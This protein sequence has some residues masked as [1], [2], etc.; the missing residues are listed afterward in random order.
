MKTGIRNQGSGIRDQG[1]GNSAAEETLRLLARLHA[2]EGLEERVQENLRVATIPAAHQARILNWPTWLRPS[3][4]WM[5]SSGMRA[6]AAAA[7]VAVV[8][9]GGWI[10]SSRLPAAQPGVAV[11][12]SPRGAAPGG[13]SSA[14]AMRTPQ[15]LDRPVVATPAQAPPRK[16]APSTKEKP[17]QPTTQTPLHYGKLTPAKKAPTEPVN[18]AGR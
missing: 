3:G 18:S 9:G 6:A 1:T 13:F 10:V 2:P 17:D 8:I 11:T 14:G 15:T 7:I 4:G 5:Q 12:A 16:A